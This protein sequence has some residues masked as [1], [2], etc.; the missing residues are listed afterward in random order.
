MNA[1]RDADG[2]AEERLPTGQLPVGQAAPGL[3]LH[4]VAGI[5]ERLSATSAAADVADAVLQPVAD[6]LGAAVANIAL[7]ADERTL[8]LM[9]TFGMPAS[10]TDPWVEFDVAA[11]I[12]LAATVREGIPYW[13]SDE[14][15]ARELFPALPAYGV[16]RS[17]CTLPLR[18]GSEVIGVLGLGWAERHEFSAPEQQTLQTVAA[19]TAAALARQRPVRPDQLRVHEHDGPD[20]VSIACLARS[21]GARC[22]VHRPKEGSRP[23]S[24][25][26]FAT[27][28]DA[29]PEL[30][31]STVERASGVLAL[32]RRRGTP[33][34][35]VGQ[36]IAEI[37]DDL[38]GPIT[39]AHIEV[40]VET[41]WLAVAPLDHAIV[42]ASTAGG[43]GRP[44]PPRPGVLAG[45]LV[46]MADG[47]A[48]AVLVVALDAHTDEDSAALIA[49]I[50]D[51][52]AAGPLPADAAA[53]LAA[54]AEELHTSETTPCVRGALAVL[55]A[56]APEQ[57][58]RTR[59]L[60]AQ[61]VSALL[62]RRFAVSA[63]PPDAGGDVEH[64]AATVADELISNAVRHAHEHVEVTIAD[65]PEGTRID[66]SDD[67]DRA[68]LVDD[69]HDEERESGRGLTLIQ[70]LSDDLE[71]TP[72]PAGGKTV[73]SLLRWRRR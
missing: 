11:G 54:L 65:L 28:L 21:G 9:A 48:A 69:R 33:P 67:D 15:H 55:T 64:L 17:L 19:L 72:R 58:V 3:M 46:V 16:S 47:D 68:P 51:R 10:V 50:A 60:P 41:R 53:L 70:A 63:L 26:V 52:V 35:L 57:S 49:A 13:L 34:A 44:T 30:P 4:L 12:P 14:A 18:V 36:A 59:T 40:D 5:A 1:T 37:S 25:S 31:T 29:H 23:G 8:H 38:D 2:P 24:T 61:P 42:I 56:A 62:G 45:E 32:C 6:L 20:G 43:A 27:M 73:S 7:R 39:G 22:T 66:V 71:V